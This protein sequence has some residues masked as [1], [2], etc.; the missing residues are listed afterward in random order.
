MRMADLFGRLAR[1]RTDGTAKSAADGDMAENVF[2]DSLD[3]LTKDD[4]ELNELAA[5]KQKSSWTDWVSRIIFWVALVVFIGSCLMLIDNLVSKYRAAKLYDQLAEEF[6]AGGF[7]MVE[8][9][10][11]TDARIGASDLLSVDG[12][13]YTLSPVAEMKQGQETP[14]PVTPAEQPTYNENLVKMRASLTSLARINPD[15]Y[16]YI[17]VQGTNI[18]YPVV[19]GTDNVYYLDHAYTGDYLPVGSIFADCNNAKDVTE[20]YNTVLYGHNITSGAMFHDVTK[21]LK[22]E[23]FAD[24]LIYL[25]T[26]DG[27]FVYEVFSAYDTRYD[28]PY[29]K[30]DFEDGEDFVRF[31]GEVRD[32]SKIK[33]DLEFTEDDRILTLS[34]CTNGPYY[35]RYALHAR[36]I[37]TILD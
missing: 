9:R 24:H 26:M 25:Y 33:K 2:R 17:Q 21:F 31:A 8:E 37:Q 3:G 22:K 30:T 13:T 19:Q 35:E 4:I 34:T 7:N 12:E 6:F 11:D 16:G 15:L 23:Y 27:I 29:F 5:K 36:L 28:Y 18:N 20:N 10:T 1:R 32:N 14:P